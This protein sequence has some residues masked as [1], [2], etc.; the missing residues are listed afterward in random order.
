MQSEL[1]AVR[2]EKGAHEREAAA[3]NSVTSELKDQARE[4]QELRVAER[5]VAEADKRQ[6]NE[7]LE[8][9]RKR[10]EEAEKTLQGELG[11]VM[12]LL[13]LPACAGRASHSLCARPSPL[14][15]HREGAGGPGA[16]GYGGAGAAVGGGVAEE[17]FWEQVRRTPLRPT[18]LPT[19]HHT[20]AHTC[21]LP[22]PPL[23]SDSSQLEKLAKLAAERD[24]LAHAVQ[25]SSAQ[26]EEVT[27][28]QARIEELEGQVFD[29]EAARRK[30][31]NKVQELRGNVRVFSRVRP[32][33]A[34]DGEG[35][36][37]G[38]EAPTPVLCR[39]DAM[40][41]KVEPTKEGG[42][43]HTFSFDRVFQPS[44]SQK[45]VFNEVSDFVQSALDGYNVC[46]FSYGQTGSG[47]THTVRVHSLIA[48]LPQPLAPWLLTPGR[49]W[50]QMQGSVTGDERGIIPRSMEKIV[51]CT[52][53]LRLRGWEYRMEASFLEIYN[54][55]I[56]DLLDRAN[57]GGAAAG[58][59]GGASG[60]KLALGGNGAPEVK[61]LT[62][63]P[64]ATEEDVEGLMARA[65]QARSVSSTSMNEQSSRSHSVFSLRLRGVHREHG[66]ALTGSL[67]LV[68]LAGSERLARS[69]A[70]GARLK[71]T[72]AINKSLSCLADV[73]AAIGRK[74]SHVRCLLP[75]CWPPLMSGTD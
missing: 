10:A 73:F 43:P 41:L 24:R 65:A 32:M 15:A 22:H 58:G 68:D 9:S 56:R 67:N 2:A 14:S 61:G 47:K 13:L 62:W 7:R 55:S 64:V 34:M 44:A 18:P 59:S 36:G 66:V 45:D 70:E 26:R 20:H 42:E 27:R 69:K 30:L 8:E 74:A 53:K 37:E 50:A 33:L 23:L 19:L 6:L 63:D 25:D 11:P 48:P 1:E 28:M 75:A 21:A 51:Q 3:L 17:Q 49:G 52:H 57:K 54:E 5:A 31:H 71:E 12:G 60:L 35:A 4:A 16:E 46:L 38:D 39:P 29:C 72:Q 40:G